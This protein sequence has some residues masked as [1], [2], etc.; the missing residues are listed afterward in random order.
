MAAATRAATGIKIFGLGQAAK[1]KRLGQRSVDL[2][3]DFLNLLLCFEKILGGRIL[4]K[5]SAHAFEFGDLRRLEFSAQ[6][7]L[8]L[9]VRAAV[10]QHLKLVFE[11]FVVEKQFDLFV[12][13]RKERLVEDVLAKLSGFVLDRECG[14]G[15]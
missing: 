11:R 15:C 9:Q 12:Q 2:I 13:F 5:G 4:E 1:F 10:V 8:L 7:L 3:L 14:G 6:R